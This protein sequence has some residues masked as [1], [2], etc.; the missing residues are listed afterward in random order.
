VLPYVGVTLGLCLLP[1]VEALSIGA[2]VLLPWPATVVMTETARRSITYALSRPC[3]EIL[4][5]AVAPKERYASKIVIDTLAVRLGDA[6]ASIL[7]DLFSA[8]SNTALMG[9]ELALM[10]GVAVAFALHI[11]RKFSAATPALATTGSPPRE[12]K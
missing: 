5:T 3:R 11:G 4:F 7:Y 9:V 1:L 6:G 12:R 10:M 8:Q 2:M